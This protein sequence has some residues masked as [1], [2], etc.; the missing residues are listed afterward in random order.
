M[1]AFIFPGQGIQKAYMG[2]DLYYKYPAAKELLDMADELLG[3]S[4]SKIMIDSDEIEL[5]KSFNAQP[6]IF[7]YE[8]ILATIQKDIVPDIVAGHSFGEFAALVINKTLKFEDALRLVD[9]RSNFGSEFSKNFDSAMA[10]VIGLDDKIVED[11]ILSITE[12]TN[13]SIFVANYNGPGQLVLSGSRIGIK[14][15]CKVFK[16]L[17][18]KRAVILPIEGAF[19]TPLMKHIELGY[20]HSINKFDFKDPIIPICQCTDSQIYLNSEKIKSNL[21][22]HMTSS[23]N[24]TKMIHNMVNYGVTEFIEIGTDDTL[25][26]I[27]KRM[28]PNII[29][30]SMLSSKTYDGFVRNYSI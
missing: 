9:I 20:N 19:H 14:E 22:Y 17:G 21:M 11:T 15:A 13:E 5:S 10:A 7:L 28:Y 6:A 1:K 30:F 25:Q 16:S 8:V 29:T 2:K 26:K 23:V 4:I 18:A 24:W 12:N 3:R 27:I